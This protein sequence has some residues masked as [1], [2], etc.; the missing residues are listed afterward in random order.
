MDGTGKSK[1]LQEV[2]ADLKNLHLLAKTDISGLTG[3]VDFGEALKSL[4]RFM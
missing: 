4:I 3:N 1:V 2:L